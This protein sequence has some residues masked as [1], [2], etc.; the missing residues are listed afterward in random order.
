MQLTDKKVDT[1]LGISVI[2]VFFLVS[3]YLVQNNLESIKYFVGYNTFG[4]IVYISFLI[5]ATVI[6]PINGVPLV[7]VASNLWGWFLTGILSVVGWT[8]GAVISFFLAR[9][10]GVPLVR[11]FVSLEKMSKF[12]RLIPQENIFWSIVFLRMAVP[13]DVLSYVL[14]LFSNIKFRTY[15]FATLIGIAPMAFV[16]AFLGGLPFYYQLIGVIG[17]ILILIVG[18]FIGK[19]YKKRRGY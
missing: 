16:I 12:E 15:V 7:P 1:I 19:W 17:S 13:V 10:Y 9:K 2:I 11:K 8:L 5:I 4:M 6:A 3:S 14:G 18:Y